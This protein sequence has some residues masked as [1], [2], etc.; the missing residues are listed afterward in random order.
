MITFYH[1]SIRYRRSLNLDDT[2]KNRKL[3]E[4][5]ILPELMYMINSGE[6]FNKTAQDEIPKV[7]VFME[8]SF[9]LHKDD[10]GKLTEDSYR[11]A[12]RLHIYP[13]FEN[14]RIDSIKPSDLIKWQNKLREKLSPKRVKFIRTIFNTMFNDAIKDEI[15][16][17]NP[18]KHVSTPKD[19]AIKI[20]KPFQIE[21]MGKIIETAKKQMQAF[22]AIG[23]LTGMRTGEIIGL[24]WIDIHLDERIIQVRRSR[25][26]GIED[27]PKTPHSI[28]DIDILDELLP[29]LIEHRRIMREDSIYLF[30]TQKRKPYYST[31]KVSWSY[32]KPVLAKLGLEYRDMYQMRHS[33]ASMMISNGEDILWVSHTLGHKD[34]SIT[35]KAYAKYIKV[36]KR[37]RAKFLK[38]SDTFGHNL[39]TVTKKSEKKP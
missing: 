37:K 29:Y 7:G 19:K 13:Y 28:R 38:E 30:E 18:F 35:L 31:S 15:I 6:F 39:V 10:R 33:F 27:V 5:E 22:F 8:I 14:K 9:I 24:K 11:G 20:R 12:C 3:A 4:R 1:Q 16:E 32:W 23:F 34:S 25:R 17:K 26:A 21:E 2:K 36:P